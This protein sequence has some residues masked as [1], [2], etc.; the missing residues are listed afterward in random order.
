MSG[1]PLVFVSYRRDDS[2]EWAA[3]IVDSLQRQFGRD[4]VF[5]DTE[6][7]RVGDEWPSKIEV[8]LQQATVFL[9]IIGPQWLAVHDESWR[10]R[11]DLP[12]D[13]VRC[14]IEYALIN[15]KPIVSVLV[16]G[17]SVPRGEA[18]PPTLVELPN[19]QAIRLED[20]ADIRSLVDFLVG[21]YNFR[22]I[23]SELDY[24]TPH[25]KQPELPEVELAEVLNSLP[26][27]SRTERDSS[28]GKIGIA[29]EL[30]RVYKFKAFD[31]AIHFMA[32]AARYIRV[33][34][35][36]PLWENQYQDIRVRL[37]TWDVGLR[38]TWKDIRLAKY[39]DR[40]YLDYVVYDRGGKLGEVL[41]TSQKEG[42][43]ID[44]E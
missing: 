36:H 38:L 30:E 8:A 24:P 31:D 27:W 43:E 23:A 3:L 29:V 1:R 12:E 19:R 44:V 41:G 25:D 4:A 34:D 17:A 2:R 16:S 26:E 28:K 37:S 20:K 5:L 40:L 39:L 6:S 7:I 35:H 13:W 22:V 15:R 33:T 18:L 21:R 9:A 11:I 32:T 14:E 42:E 10:R